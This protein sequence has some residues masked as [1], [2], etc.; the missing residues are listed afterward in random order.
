MIN[1]TPLIDTLFLLLIFLVVTSRFVE[2]PGI[3]VNLPKAGTA[4]LLKTG[5]VVVYVDA[6]GG[7]YMGGKKIIQGTL[8]GILEGKKKAQPDFALVLRADREAPYGKVVAVL[9]AAKAAGIERVISATSFG[10]NS[11]DGGDEAL[12]DQ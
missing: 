11:S 9:D 5:D 7:I 8:V 12:N 3:K 6:V 1:L 2:H 4:E 10:A